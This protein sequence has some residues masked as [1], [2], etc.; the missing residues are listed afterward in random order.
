MLTVLHASHISNTTPPQG[1]GGIELI[2]DI[3]AKYQTRE[4]LNVRVMGVKNPD[5]RISYEFI[6]IF[7][8]PVKR[9]SVIHKLRYLLKIL[10]EAKDNDLVH[11]HVQWLTVIVP[12]LQYLK[13]PTL[14]TLHADLSD[15]I[16]AYLV[17]KFNTALIAISYTQKERMRKRGFEIYDVIYHGIEI[18]KYPFVKDKEDYLIYVGRIDQSKG[19]HIAV[20]IAKRLGEKLV[21]IGPIAD[22][23]YFENYV[24]TFIDGKHIIYLGEVDFKTKVQYLS[25]AKALIYPVQYEEFFGLAVVEALASGTPVI[26]FARGSLKEI[27]IHGVTGFLVNTEEEMLKYIK[28]LNDLSPE[29]CRKDAEKRFSAQIMVK[30]YIDAYNRLLEK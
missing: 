9:P 27:I 11:L 2:V 29:A 23:T 14:L 4:G 7:K 17:R 5:A 26:G 30:K 16:I 25:K 21:I 12:I 15:D 8:D 19:T 20:S 3:L 24:K 6:Q 13:I 28:S 10:K 1:Y 22:N 18:E